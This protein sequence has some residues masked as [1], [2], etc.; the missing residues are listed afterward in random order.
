MVG[1][2]RGGGNVDRGWG[3]A[4]WGTWRM[5]VSKAEMGAWSRYIFDMGEMHS[6]DVA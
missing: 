4:R 6:E 1:L 3:R 2:E 5:V